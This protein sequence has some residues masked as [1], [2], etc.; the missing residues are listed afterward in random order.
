ML[1]E[2]TRSTKFYH[3]AFRTE[4]ISQELRLFPSSGEKVERQR[5]GSVHYEGLASITGPLARSNGPNST[6]AFW[7]L[8]WRQKQIQFPKCHILFRI[9]DDAWIPEIQCISKPF[10]KSPVFVLSV[11]HNQESAVMIRQHVNRSLIKHQH[12]NYSVKNDQITVGSAINFQPDLQDLKQFLKVR[13]SQFSQQCMLRSQSSGMCYRNRHHR[14]SRMP[15]LHLQ[16][17]LTVQVA[18]SSKTLQS[19]WQ[20]SRCHNPEQCTL[21]SCLLWMFA[22]WEG[23]L[24]IFCCQL[25]NWQP[26]QYFLPKAKHTRQPTV[27]TWHIDKPD[28]WVQQ[29]SEKQTRWVWLTDTFTL[30]VH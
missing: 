24:P 12:S 30:L 3:P 17:T 5:L 23:L 15:C 20:T 18:G 4:Y 6:G 26:H 29:N 9:L 28:S 8:H 1:E 14:F 27:N 22:V 2:R 16:G 11:R 25:G 10:G 7:P 19:M 21:R 13:D